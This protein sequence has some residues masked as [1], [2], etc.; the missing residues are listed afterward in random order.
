MPV[1]VGAVGGASAAAVVAVVAV[2][3][4]AVDAEEGLR[5]RERGRLPV[6][7]WAAAGEETWTPAGRA[8]SSTAAAAG[9]GP[10]AGRQGSGRSGG[11]SLPG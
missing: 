6:A 4:G 11:R 7:G 8:S 5:R 2:V 3:V 10:F 1:A 9:R